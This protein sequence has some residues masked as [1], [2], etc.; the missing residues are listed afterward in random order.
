[1]F[2]FWGGLA[3][4][5]WGSSTPT[6]AQ[7][8]GEATRSAQ[9]RRLD[10]LAHNTV[11]SVLQDRRG[12][13]WI[14]T[15]DGLVRYDGYD[16]TVYRHAPSDSTSISNN[17]IRT[18]AN[19]PGG[20]LWVGTSNG[21]NQFDPETRSF[22]RYPLDSAS[23]PHDVAAVHV[24]MAGGVW[25]ST[26]RPSGVFRRPPGSDRF[27]RVRVAELELPSGSDAGVDF[28]SD[29]NN[30]VW[31]TA[32]QNNRAH[33]FRYEVQ[34]NRF[35]SVTPLP[36]DTYIAA[37]DRDTLWLRSPGS[38][39]QT[40]S[41]ITLQTLPALP[42]SLHEGPV[43]E[44]QT[45][46]LWIGTDKG[47]VRYRP[48]T[49][50][51]RFDV[52]D[53]SHA[54]ELSNFV[55]ALH[56]DRAGGVWIG[57]RSGLYYHNPH[58]KPFRHLQPKAQTGQPV[59]DPVM[60]IRGSP[61]GLVLGTLGGDVLRVPP[62]TD[63][64]QPPDDGAD[65]IPVPGDNVWALHPTPGG[66]LW[67][68]T[69]QGL[70]LLDA[71]QGHCANLTRPSSD[72]PFVYS[73]ATGPGQDLWLGGADLY[74]F[75]PRTSR[76]LRAMGIDE[77]P[78]GHSIQSIHVDPDNRNLLWLGTEGV[79]LI[80]YHVPTGRVT[81]YPR[82]NAPSAL[83]STSIWT[84]HPG[85]R[86]HLWLGTDRG[87]VRL[88]PESGQFRSYYNPDA[89]RGGYVYSILEDARHRLWLATN[90]GL[91]RFDPDAATFRHYDASDGLKN[92]E[93][94]RGAA[95]KAQDGRFFFGGLRGVTTF[96]PDAIR[97]NPYVPPVVVTR[98]TKVNRTGPTTI[99]PTGRKEVVLD[100]RE[101][102][103][104]FEYAALNFAN[105]AKNRYM[106]RLEG[107]E[108]DW[109]EAGTRRVVRY[110]NVPPGEYVF[111]VKGSNGDGVWNEEGASMRVTITPPFWKTWWFR[112]SILVV[113][114]AVLVI[115]YRVRVGYLL[116]MERMRLRLA[117]DLH[118]DVASQL[119]SVAIT[120]DVLR[121]TA[122]VD[123]VERA[124]LRRMGTLV[125]E[126]TET[127]RDIVWFVDPDH[128]RPGALLEK[129]KTTAS[130]LLREVDHTFDH[131]TPEPVTGL[132]DLPVQARRNLFLIYKEVLHNV[133]RHACADTVRIALR[134]TTDGIELTVSDDGVGFD[135]DDEGQWGQ[136]MKTMRRR[137]EQMGADLTLTSSPGAGTTLR[138]A[139][140]GQ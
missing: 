117:S 47:V 75:N 120:S 62:L 24:D 56:E 118:D 123:E 74:R 115:L 102:V 126:T 34:H 92:R 51:L 130:T 58:A 114:I 91:A 40:V 110:T 106:Y 35:R 136:G 69:D 77:I 98:M 60:A 31:A 135:P 134:P 11:F 88:D 96:F 53:A 124:E 122:D 119:A 100:Y 42:D 21:V 89:D 90:Q 81:T 61:T 109:V 108:E 84:V 80:K 131:P 6:T 8:T 5:L 70:C 23:T 111:R 63:Q 82:G 38:V 66:A 93:Y 97:D 113:G 112:G 48:A 121:A 33:L 36:P 9:F 28:F 3:L 25:A 45:E 7:P 65:R 43:L 59:N 87:L 94:N 39:D 107:F 20:T 68:G 14:G 16:F 105:P 32:T 129:M 85:P 17:S 139:V 29:G 50:S 133:A 76:H 52:I 103:F 4:L 30:R 83:P 46:L 104:T 138:L 15:A 12:F 128:D 72:R 71:E 132:N 26:F 13:L 41:G 78:L 1:M 44:D 99:I 19:G 64:N 22:V 116:R 140:P 10:G 125:R 57:T 95:Y 27:R 86:G 79:G 127:L 67:A 101:R 2:T 73:I 18:L 37:A 54:S 55:L 137:A 49:D